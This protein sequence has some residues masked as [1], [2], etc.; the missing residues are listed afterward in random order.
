MV[1]ILLSFPVHWI[2]TTEILPCRGIAAD[3]RAKWL[4]LGGKCSA[5]CS[6]AVRNS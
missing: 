3:C 6:H 5:A 2:T 4:K 1:V